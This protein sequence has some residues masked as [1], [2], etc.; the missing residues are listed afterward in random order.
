ME[1]LTHQP[2]LDEIYRYLFCHNFEKTYCG[3]NEWNSIMKNDTFTQ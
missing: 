2:I 3:W 1:N